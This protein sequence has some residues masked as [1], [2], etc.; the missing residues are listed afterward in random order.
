[1]RGSHT[2]TPSKAPSI[3]STPNA[4]QNQTPGGSVEALSL[5]RGTSG[6]TNVSNGIGTYEGS[7][8]IP[9]NDVNVNEMDHT[10]GYGNFVELG[11]EVNINELGCCENWCEKQLKKKKKSNKKVMM[12]QILRLVVITITKII[13]QK[14]KHKNQVYK[15]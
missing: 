4:T 10:G 9:P 8:E 14:N 7:V 13:K 3:V 5:K 15:W 2:I 1:M 6:M 11:I 12:I